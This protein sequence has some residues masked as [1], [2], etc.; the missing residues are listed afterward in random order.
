M[1]VYT[2]S[3]SCCVIGVYSFTMKRIFKFGENLHLYIVSVLVE[4]EQLW[5]HWTSAFGG[6][7][8]EMSKLLFKQFIEIFVR[9]LSKQFIH[10][11]KELWEKTKKDAHRKQILKKKENKSIPEYNVIDSDTSEGKVMSKPT[12][13]TTAMKN[14]AGFA[15][16]NI[17]EIREMASSMYGLKL[18]VKCQKKRLTELFLEKG[19]ILHRDDSKPG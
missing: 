9:V 3:V 19:N 17:S 2:D 4:E 16:Y 15:K 10:D 11:I 7:S 1:T 12:L 13:K 14:P 5:G 18:P 6:T 8:I